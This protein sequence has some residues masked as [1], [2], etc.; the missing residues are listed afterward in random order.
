MQFVLIDE[1]GKAVDA[2]PAPYLDLRPLNP[3][4][5]EAAHKLLD[6]G[7][8]KGDIEKMAMP[9]P[10][11]G[12]RRRGCCGGRGAFRAG[13]PALAARCSRARG[14]RSA[15]G[16]SRGAHLPLDVHERK[17]FVARAS[18]SSSPGSGGAGSEA[19]AA[20]YRDGIVPNGARRA[21]LAVLATLHGESEFVPL[22]SPTCTAGCGAF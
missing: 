4:E 2:G 19:L 11:W 1:Q 22:S 18:K 8:L 9:H 14:T 17:T 10:K 5:K 6:A 20:Q 3:E 12:G 16:P 13:H 21:Q 15:G 7:W